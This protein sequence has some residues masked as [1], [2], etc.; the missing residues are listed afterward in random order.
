MNLEKLFEAQRVLDERIEQEHPRTENENRVP[1]KILALQVEL[2]EMANEWRGFKFWSANQE[3]RTQRHRTVSDGYRMN[4]IP[5]NP[6]LCD[7]VERM[8]FKLHNAVVVFVFAFSFKHQYPSSWR[9]WL[10]LF[11]L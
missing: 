4:V 7:T 11:F 5:Y 3:P 6:L 8:P 2:G 10:I 9:W 1:Q